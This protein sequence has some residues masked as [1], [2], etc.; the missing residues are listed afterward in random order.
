M[1]FSSDLWFNW[2]A[3]HYCATKIINWYGQAE[4]DKTRCLL[5]KGSNKVCNACKECKNASYIV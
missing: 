3:T 1:C 4:Q 5:E 2:D